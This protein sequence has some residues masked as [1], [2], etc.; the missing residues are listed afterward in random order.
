M[1]PSQT[2]A[3]RAV[4]AVVRAVLAAVRAVLARVVLAAVR[5]VLV[6]ARVVLVTARLVLVAVLAV[7]VAA[8]VVLV[9][10]WVVLAAVRAV[11]VAVRVVPAAD[12]V[13]VTVRVVPAAAR[14]VLVTVGAE[15]S[16]E[17]PGDKVRFSGRSLDSAGSPSS[18]PRHHPAGVHG[19]LQEAVL[20]GSAEEV[21]LFLNSS[22]S[23]DV[24]AKDAVGR[25]ALMLA[26]EADSPEVIDLLLKHGA[27]PNEGNAF[28]TSALYQAVCARRLR[29]AERLLLGGALVNAHSL[30]QRHAPLH[31]AC[32][33]GDARLVALLLSF[34]ADADVLDYR[35]RTPLHAAAAGGFCDCL[36]LLEADAALSAA[37]LRLLLR[38][39]PAAVQQLLDGG[40]Q[41]GD[42][43]VLLVG[44]KPLRDIGGAER[45]FEAELVTELQRSGRWDLLGHPAV[46]LLLE[47]TRQDR[48]FVY[49]TAAKILWCVVFL[50]SLLGAMVVDLYRVGSD[51]PRL[52]VALKG[53]LVTLNV[54]QL[55][56]LVVKC[57]VIGGGFFLSGRRWPVLV[58]TV[59]I[60][61]VVFLRSE[62][63]KRLVYAFSVLMAFFEFT[64]ALESISV[65][66]TTR[67]ISSLLHVTRSIAEYLLVYS[68]VLIGFSVAFSVMFGSGDVPGSNLFHGHF[69][70]I[71]MAAMV[72]GEVD[73]MEA[74]KHTPQSGLGYALSTLVFLMFV[75]L[76][77]IVM[78]NL[79]LALTISDTTKF[80]SKGGAEFLQNLA[81]RTAWNQ[82]AAFMVDGW[83]HKLKRLM[84]EWLFRHVARYSLQLKWQSVLPRPA[85]AVRATPHITVD[86]FARGGKKVRAF[87]AGYS[88]RF[89]VRSELR[90]S[91]DAIVQARRPAEPVVPPVT[92]GLDAEDDDVC[93]S[94]LGSVGTGTLLGSCEEL[95]QSTSG[96]LRSTVSSRLLSERRPLSVQ[97]RYSRAPLTHT[98]SSAGRSGRAGRTASSP[99]AHLGEQLAGIRDV[100]QRQQ[101]ALERQQDV[102]NSM[103]ERLR[104]MEDVMSKMAAAQ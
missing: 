79:L 68:P 60:F 40:V 9:T 103:L 58:K 97:R 12:L 1:G 71:N 89:R 88:R 76:V 15:T 91:L 22:S 83:V 34:G 47:L 28:G 69:L 74:E 38:E 84:P 49:H 27:E 51:I 73:V 14:V 39:R 5:V 64:M 75:V 43:G 42:G 92:T 30:R 53:V 7:L 21:R 95:C 11:L 2:A 18:R 66:K 54:F 56:F 46:E 100:L 72:L 98:V 62:P 3:D 25:T 90:Q 94:G 65:W 31:A 86:P 101:A 23:S 78:L 35:H 81:N 41:P 19:P 6:T 104:Q 8:L 13:L 59:L 99:V 52:E 16:K 77:P 33:D 20:R 82:Q 70:A 61:V 93:E 85:A 24:N 45:P 17:M 63:E 67:A 55:L 36:A 44:Y 57:A 87:V 102:E 48:Y 10:V 29:C 4:P 50:A 32:A 80:L 96:V 37:D 26:V